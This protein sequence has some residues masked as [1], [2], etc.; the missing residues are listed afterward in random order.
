MSTFNYITTDGDRIDNLADRFYGTMEGI[1]IIT[2]ANPSVPLYPIYPLGTVLLIP[3]V[4]DMEVS[5]NSDLP[6]W[7]R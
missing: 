3:I 5:D 1:S 7:K 2:D 6:P 4:A